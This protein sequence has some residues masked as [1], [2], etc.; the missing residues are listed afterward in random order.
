MKLLKVVFVLFLTASIITSCK[1][2][3]E[4]GETKETKVAKAEMLSLNVSG[5]SCEI[6]C[7]KTIESKLDKKEGVLEAKVVFADSLATIKY[8]AEKIDKASLIA[9]VEGVGD[10]NT[11]KASESNSKDVK[12]CSDSKKECCKDE[13]NKQACAEDCKKD[14]CATKKA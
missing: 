13:T 5:M 3:A 9:F 12:S 8:D 2:E 11:Y 10:G 14:N 1:S 7:A 4:K 6:G